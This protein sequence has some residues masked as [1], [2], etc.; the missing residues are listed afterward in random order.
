MAKKKTDEITFKFKLK[1]K[2]DV[3]DKIKKYGEDKGVVQSIERHLERM[4]VEWFEQMEALVE[5]AEE[6]EAGGDIIVTPSKV[7]LGPDG[8][9]MGNA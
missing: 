3:Y 4:M 8:Q 1:V 5:V 6:A 2:Q 7:I 9:P